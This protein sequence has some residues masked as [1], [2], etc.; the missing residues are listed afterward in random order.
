VADG[1]I[2][3][4]RNLVSSAHNSGTHQLRVERWVG[5][6]RSSNTI[7]Q[8]DDASLAACMARVEAL[9]KPLD[10][11]GSPSWPGAN[12]SY[13][14]PALRSAASLTLTP[15]LR[16]S[17]AYE[18][19]APSVAKDYQAAGFLGVTDMA[20]CVMNSRGLFTYFA[21]TGV[22]F[23]TTIRSPEKR[24]SGWAG[25]TSFDWAKIDAKAL[26]ER[27]LDKCERSMNPVGI[28]PGRYTAI[29]EPQ[30]VAELLRP[31]SSSGRRSRIGPV[32]RG[33]APS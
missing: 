18:T 16:S 13:E 27:A 33:E 23:S 24:A 5:G 7:N 6:R 3:W 21:E 11:G 22:E 14:A 1:G 26:A 32:P 31:P 30:A 9:G 28:E 25:V 2:R 12:T 4:G 15:A 8:I 17:A 19:V 29:L 10:P 20:T